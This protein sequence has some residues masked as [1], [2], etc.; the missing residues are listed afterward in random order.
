MEALACLLEEAAGEEILGVRER[1]GRE[2]ATVDGD[3]DDAAVAALEND[4]IWIR[5]KKRKRRH[6]VDGLSST[7]RP[8]KRPPAKSD[9]RKSAGKIRERAAV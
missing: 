3:R 4:G 1:R 6:G 2:G 7:P 9:L 8:R 5:N